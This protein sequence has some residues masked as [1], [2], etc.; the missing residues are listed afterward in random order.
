MQTVYRESGEMTAYC[1]YLQVKWNGME[2]YRTA[3][4]NIR[5][6][7]IKI[8]YVLIQETFQ[9]FLEIA[10]LDKKQNRLTF[11]ADLQAGSYCIQVRFCAN[12]IK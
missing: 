7:S 3:G 11:K 5:I 2:H 10:Q 12:F 1:A 6:Y 4:N 9:L 8:Q